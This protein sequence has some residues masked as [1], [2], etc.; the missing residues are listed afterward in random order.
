MGESGVVK[1]DRYGDRSDIE[2]VLTN[3]ETDALQGTWS[4]S[5]GLLLN[6]NGHRGREKKGKTSWNLSGEPL[7]I[8]TV[9]V[10]CA[11]HQSVQF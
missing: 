9:L 8:T 2:L 11:Q 6:T 7:V 3:L 4:S 10:R 1:V 5:S